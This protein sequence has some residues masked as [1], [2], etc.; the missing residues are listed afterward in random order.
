MSLHE[1]PLDNAFW[2]HSLRRYAMPSVSAACLQ[3][4]DK[5]N[6][7]INL[8]L[9]ADWFGEQGIVITCKDWEL[10]Q[11][12]IYDWHTHVVSGLR[13][14]RKYLKVDAQA[15]AIAILRNNIKE[16]ELF[17]EQITQSILYEQ[18][19]TLINMHDY[20]AQFTTVF[21]SQE[22]IK[23]YFFICLSV[24]IDQD[25][26]CAESVVRLFSS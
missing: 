6:A 1:A 7:N 19:I 10:L 26:V 12:T 5:Y 8:L 23:N 11:A 20:Q 2:Q 24:D 14:V 15:N 13:K 4:Q 3:L 18:A 22:N 16:Q 9:L 21:A 25:A 17:A